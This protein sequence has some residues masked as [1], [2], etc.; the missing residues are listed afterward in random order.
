VSCS[1][2]LLR[3]LD[4][5]IAY[6]LDVWQW[7]S[8]TWLM[9]VVPAHTAFARLAFRN[10][11]ASVTSVADLCTSVTSPTSHHHQVPS[12]LISF[13]LT[14]AVVPSADNPAQRQ[15]LRDI[16]PTPVVVTLRMSYSKQSGRVAQPKLP[17][18]P[19][20][21]HQALTHALTPLIINTVHR[22]GNGHGAHRTDQG[23]G[24][25]GR[26]LLSQRID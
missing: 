3:L 21:Y 25:C 1:G 8:S 2:A 22:L 5:L 23:W 18:A 16:K 11:Q 19:R 14:S 4:L 12:H 10:G 7:I 24:G 17:Q 6:F 15:N 9:S 20:L 13:H 26:K